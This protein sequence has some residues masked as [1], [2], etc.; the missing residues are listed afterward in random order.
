MALHAIRIQQLQDSDF[1]FLIRNCRDPDQLR[2]GLRQLAAV[3]IARALADVQRLQ[4]SF[5][6]RANLLREHCEACRGALL[7]G[8][9]SRDFRLPLV[10]QR[11]RN[12]DADYRSVR[13]ARP[14]IGALQPGV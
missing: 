10:K 1:A 2:T 8:R 12:R 13:N 7:L 14:D 6:R 5:H 9:V 3:L 4:R 11:K